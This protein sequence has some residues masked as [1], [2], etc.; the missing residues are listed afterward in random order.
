MS[1]API[2]DTPKRTLESITAWS[3]A[4]AHLRSLSSA[5]ALA[6]QV[7]NPNGERS[8]AI[9][10]GKGDVP[11]DA[12]AYTITALE[13]Q[14]PPNASLFSLYDQR[15]LQGIAA[16]YHGQIAAAVLKYLSL[17][18]HLSLRSISPTR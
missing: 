18:R 4:R 7:D 6:N 14:L 10:N 1:V 2:P 12:D 3:I 8:V 17:N 9:P 15:F 11:V 13:S 5:G 16:S